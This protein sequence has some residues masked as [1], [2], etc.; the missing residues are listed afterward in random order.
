M[1]FFSCGISLIEILTCG[2]AVSYKLEICG[3]SSLFDIRISMFFAMC[4]VASYMEIAM[5][6]AVCVVKGTRKF[7]RTLPYVL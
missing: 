3:F 1:K 7:P 5:Y 2:I 6:L 4:F